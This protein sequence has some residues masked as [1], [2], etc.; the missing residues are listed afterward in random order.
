MTADYIAFHAEQRPDAP[1]FLSNGNAVSYAVVASNIRSFTRRLREFE[2]PAGGTVVVGCENV[3]I[4]LVILFACERLGLATASLI[5]NEREVALPLLEGAGLVLSETPLPERARPRRSEILNQ[6]WIDGAQ[7]LSAVETEP[8]PVPPA[9]SALRILRTSGTTG[10]PKRLHLTRR[11]FDAWTSRWIW[12][13]GLGIGTRTL[14]VMPF[15]IGGA[16][17]QICATLRA[18][19][20]VVREGRMEVAEALRTHKI[21]LVVMLPTHLRE[22]LAKMAVGFE[23]MPGL[24]IATFGGAISA[25]LRAEAVARLCGALSDMY[26]CN[27]VGFIGTNGLHRAADN[28]DIWPGVAIEAVDEE[29]R[30]LPWGQPGRLRVRTESMFSGYLDDPR[31]TQRMLRDGWF[32]PGDIGVLHGPRRLELLGRADDLLN[33]EGRKVLPEALEEHLRRASGIAELAI[34]SVLGR[35]GAA[36]LC[37]ALVGTGPLDTQTM[38][39][40]EASVGGAGFRKFALVWLPR[41]PRNHAG[42]LQRN[43]LKTEIDAARRNRPSG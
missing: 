42:K 5:A 2:I 34:G 18:G 13:Y 15:S 29:G 17:A 24:V 1:A 16:Y 8:L 26:G 14:T 27:E 36:E 22:V 39:R 37:I 41:L 30:S 10:A 38:S 33:F 40:L 9:E 3:Y 28:L 23:P 21:D 6:A 11:M 32:Y 25:S 43:V 19:G 4:H 12:C 31:T 35:D 20:T 7:G